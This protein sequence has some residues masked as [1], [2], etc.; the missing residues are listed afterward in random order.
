MAAQCLYH[1]VAITV[2]PPIH[3]PI[4][5]GSRQLLYK[6]PAVRGPI[7]ASSNRP[8]ARSNQ[9]WCI[10]DRNDPPLRQKW[11]AFAFRW[12]IL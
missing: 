9:W 2:I 6:Y 4:G 5:Y 3:G 10:C 11:P 7:D 12:E 1:H 8:V